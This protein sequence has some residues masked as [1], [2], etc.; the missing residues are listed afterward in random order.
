MT[1][2]QFY[3]MF[4][5]TTIQVWGKDKPYLCRIKVIFVRFND[6]HFFCAEI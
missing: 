6:Q 4:N 2:Y 3:Q 1:K 5:M